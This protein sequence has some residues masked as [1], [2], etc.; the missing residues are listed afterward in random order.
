M[1]ELLNEFVRKQYIEEELEYSR[2]YRYLDRYMCATG[3]GSVYTPKQEVKENKTIWSLWLQGLDRITKLS[4]LCMDSV[5]RNLPEGFDYVVLTEETMS[6]YIQL[7]DYIWDKYRLGMI[8]RTH[9]SDV[10]RLELLCTYGGCWIDSTVFCSEPIRPYMISGDLFFFQDSI[11]SQPVIKMSNWWIYSIK[12]YPLIIKT[13]DILFES[14]KNEDR[15]VNYYLFHIIMSRLLDEGE[16]KGLLRMK[17]PYFS[18]SSAHILWGKMGSRY[19]QEEWEIIKE[20]S[21]VHK[22]SNK[23]KFLRGDIFNYYCAFMDGLLK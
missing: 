5:R 22:L 21:P 1:E 12:E 10:I 18:N 4:E 6:D 19:S 16:F 13:R 11:M 14:W 17:M 15:I 8:S 2:V 20:V 23:D 3:N 9:M 7:P